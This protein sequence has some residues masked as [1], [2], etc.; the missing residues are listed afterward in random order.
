MKNSRELKE[1]RPVVL[2]SLVMNIFERILK[3][4]TLSMI[5]GKLDRLQFAYQAGK[6]VEDAKLFILDCVYKHL[7]KPKSHVRLLFADFSLAFNKMQPHILI[8]HLASHF[9]LP[10]QLLRLFLD[11]LT[12]RV[13]QVSHVA[14]HM[15]TT[16]ISSTGSLQGCVLSPLLFIKYTDNCRNPQEGSFLVTFSD[17]TVLLSLES[18]LPHAPHPPCSSPSRVRSMITAMHYLFC[19]MVW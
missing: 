18:F 15:S 2:T 5:D 8:E 1:F 3:D 6:G 12:D 13:Q 9:K 7:E 17:D 19:E 10:D 16:V 4:M 14:G 11:F